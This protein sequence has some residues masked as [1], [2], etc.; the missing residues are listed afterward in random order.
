MA[1]TPDPALAEEAAETPAD[2]A[3]EDAPP[4]AP[5]AP[6]P[7][8]AIPVPP[9]VFNTTPPPAAPTPPPAP[10]VD[11]L[12]SAGDDDPA[13][14]ALKARV[15]ALEVKINAVGHQADLMEQARANGLLEQQATSAPETA[16][17]QCSRC[18]EEGV[19]DPATNA[20]PVLVEIH[21]DRWY[22]AYGPITCPIH[23]GQPELMVCLEKRDQALKEEEYRQQ[24]AVSTALSQPKPAP[25]PPPGGDFGDVAPAPPALQAPLVR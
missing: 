20:A 14:A 10:P 1:F 8:Q 22:A 18:I 13:L 23:K 21:P 24:M 19:L 4:P 17:Y 11:L 9:P 12:G 25:L 16:H 2:E 3:I 5:V 7:A 6:P 15:D